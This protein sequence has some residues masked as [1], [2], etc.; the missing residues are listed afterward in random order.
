MENL[1]QLAQFSTET[2]H[3]YNFESESHPNYMR[4]HS[5]QQL[6]KNTSDRG[7]IPHIPASSTSLS[8]TMDCTNSYPSPPFDMNFMVNEW[9]ENQMCFGH[10]WSETQIALS[11][12]HSGM[13]QAEFYLQSEP[14]WP[15]ENLQSDTMLDSLL[16]QGTLPESGYDTQE[17]PAFWNY[18]TPIA[19]TPPANSDRHSYPEAYEI[20]E[21]SCTPAQPSPK[22]G[23]MCEVCGV[24]CNKLH[25]LKYVRSIVL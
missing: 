10:D 14:F 18:S 25:L 5:S 3:D 23:Y 21:K 17:L 13:A 6:E 16:S 20:L 7:R 4:I 1:H 8:I 9:T 11:E 22:A 24:T 19:S 2:H 12:F 15:L